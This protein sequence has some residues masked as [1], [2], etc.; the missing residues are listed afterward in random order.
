MAQTGYTPISLY[1]TTTA[2][3]VPTAGNLVNGEL[4][5]NINTADGKLFYKD[6]AGVVQTLATKGTAAIGGATT[7]VQYNNAGTLAGSANMVFDGSTLTTLNTAY[8]G[9]FTGGTGVVNLGSGQFYK[10]ASGNVGI[11]TNSPSQILDI[12]K[13]EANLALESTTGTNATWIRPKN[14]GGNF[15]FGI[16]NSTGTG[17][18]A[19]A[20]G[21]VLYSD[22]AY[23]VI[24]FNN[25]SERM[26]IDSSGNVG[27][28][29]S[30]PNTKLQI[31]GSSTT[32]LILSR[33]T[34][35][36]N[37]SNTT[38][39]AT[40][41]LCITDSVNTQKDV[42]YLTAYPDNINAVGGG[43]T[44]STQSAD[45]NMYERMRVDSSGNFLVGTTNT[46]YNVRTNITFT[47]ASVNGV[48]IDDTSASG[49][50]YMLL[51]TTTGKAANNTQTTAAFID[52]SATRWE[53]R[54]NGGLANYQA[55]N[56]NLSDKREKNNI[57]LAG[58][59]LNKICSIPVKTFNYIDQN[60]EDDHGT[61]L[62]VIAQDVQSVA[63]ELVQESDWSKDRD[64]SKIRLSIYQTDLQYA[65][66]KSIQEQQVMIEE[67]KAKVAALEAA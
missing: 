50:P 28:G 18:S 15:Y 34:N 36:S 12:K 24:F 40:I 16:D 41:A 43:L 62:G 42:A 11:G 5:L 47:G 4:A 53:F 58:N 23:P 64:G 35:T 63:P 26:R 32:N 19:G 13:T 51:L 31:A 56:V 38:K 67:L 1:Y 10:D 2:S 6:S 3:A 22:G 14:T 27:V 37:A 48:R 46:G 61:T 39:N 25:G 66:M 30:S 54:A 59:Y 9:T 55:N 57:E 33:F 8:T 49:S 7:Q 44:F 65:L 45:T 52:T 17:F 60:I 20:Y 29:T 21:R